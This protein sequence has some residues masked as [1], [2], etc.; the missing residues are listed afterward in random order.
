[1]KITIDDTIK[2]ETAYFDKE[3]QKNQRRLAK[4]KKEE[5]MREEFRAAHEDAR[6]AEVLNDY[7][8]YHR[9]RQL[10]LEELQV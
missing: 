4:L 5:Y 7:S 1:M 9:R 3:K 6:E 10:Q 2:H 8:D